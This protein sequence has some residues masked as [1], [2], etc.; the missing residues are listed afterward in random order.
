MS[1]FLGAVEGQYLEVKT[2]VGYD[3]ETAAGRFELVKDVTAFANAS[4]GFLLLGL[5]TE[6]AGGERT[7]VVRSL[8]L[9]QK[10][11]VGVSKVVGIVNQL[12]HPT[13]DGLL[14]HWYPSSENPSVGVFAI[15]VPAQNDN[16]KFFLQ[17][18]VVNAGE[19]L[20]Q[21]V[22]GIAVRHDGDNL[23][24]GM[25]ELYRVTQSGRNDVATRL[26]RIE[27]KID[28]LGPQQTARS[29]PLERLADRLGA[30]A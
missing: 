12:S 28:T 1:D 21:V 13:I 18:E 23:P 20:K 7:D 3:L 19:S 5:K 30:M 2:G 8:D 6:R 27:E 22:F 15:Y 16:R 11:A 29:S 9:V 26:T 24:F 4:G 14:A 10:D 25:A 17:G